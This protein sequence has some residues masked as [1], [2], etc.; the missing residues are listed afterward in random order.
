MG[1]RRRGVE[2]GPREEGRR[3]GTREEGRN[4]GREVMSLLKQTSKLSHLF[5]LL[6]VDRDE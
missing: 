3:K 1:G 4:G 5:L 2:G 6:F